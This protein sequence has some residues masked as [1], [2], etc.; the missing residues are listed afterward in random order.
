MRRVAPRAERTPLRPKNLGASTFRVDARPLR[1]RVA[2]HGRAPRHEARIG[3]PSLG[4]GAR[5]PTPL[6]AFLL[7]FDRG[8]PRP[9]KARVE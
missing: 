1:R 9:E 8:A 2:S 4:N 7:D 3:R 6:R 5:H